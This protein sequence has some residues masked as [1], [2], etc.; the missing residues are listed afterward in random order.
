MS[1]GIYS[2]NDLLYNF[3][4]KTCAARKL[5]NPEVKNI[6]KIK[7]SCKIYIIYNKMLSI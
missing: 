3:L 7:D 4:E 6:I 5:N 1:C 2:S